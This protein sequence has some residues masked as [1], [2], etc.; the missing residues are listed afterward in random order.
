MQQNPLP[1]QALD[2]ERFVRVLSLQFLHH[3][4]QF[5]VQLQHRCTFSSLY[6]CESEEAKKDVFET[7]HTHFFIEDIPQI[8]NV[9]EDR[10]VATYPTVDMKGCSLTFSLST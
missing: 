3:V 8:G 6:Q 5:T 9:L 2:D 4:V 10:H 7:Y 1:V